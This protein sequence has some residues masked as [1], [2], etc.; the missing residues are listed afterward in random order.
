MRYLLPGRR[1]G[2][3]KSAKRAASEKLGIIR[4]VKDFPDLDRRDP[5]FRL[6]VVEW[7]AGAFGQLDRWSK[8]ITAWHNHCECRNLHRSGRAF[9]IDCSDHRGPINCD[10]PARTGDAPT[11]RG[12]HVLL[13]SCGFFWHRAAGIGPPKCPMTGGK[14]DWIFFLKSFPTCG[15]RRVTANHRLVRWWIGKPVSRL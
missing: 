7:H 11:E 9:G 13:G 14:G 1:F 3:A 6:S 10:V 4:L 15:D 8:S 2:K 5:V 12:V